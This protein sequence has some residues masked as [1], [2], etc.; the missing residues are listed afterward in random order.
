MLK[1][2]ALKLDLRKGL[3]PFMSPSA[4]RVE[5]LTVPRFQFV[6][7]DGEIEPGFGP[8]TSPNFAEALEALYG[9]SYTLKFMLKLREFDPVDY[10]VSALEGLWWVEDMPFDITKPTGWR[11]SVM[12]LQPGL[13]TPDLYADALKQLR[14]KRGDK[15]AFTK[16]RLE[17]FEEGLCIQT[18]HIGPYSTEMETMLKID[19]Y[20]AENGYRM[21]GRH[22]EIY[23]GDPRRAQPEKLKTILRHQ[24]EKM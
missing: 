16:L 7:I 11:Y 12:I 21:V 15:P 18:L 9:I 10:P 3:K 17:P 13:I 20:A 22:H 8:G 6:M 23:M 24:V 19:A 1:P 4:K 14:K 5:L 2:T